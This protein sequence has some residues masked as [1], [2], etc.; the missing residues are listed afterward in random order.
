VTFLWGIFLG[1]FAHVYKLVLAKMVCW[2]A[3]YIFG[4][5]IINR[6]LSDQTVSKLTDFCFICDDVSAFAEY[7]HFHKSPINSK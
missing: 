5:G 6:V 4:E 1:D 7:E 2:P 3:V